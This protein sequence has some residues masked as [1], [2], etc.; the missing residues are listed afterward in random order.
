M[1]KAR[2]LVV[3]DDVNLARLA[4]MVLENSGRYHVM[5]EC[6]STRA[7]GVARHFRP[8]LLLLDVDMPVKS[9]SDVLREIEADDSLHDTPVVFL[10]G[11]LKKEQIGDELHESAGKFFLSKP[12]LP[13]VLLSC[14]AEVLGAKAA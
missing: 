13:E 9:G 8:E 2:V 12:V 7:L 10:T 3:D 1:G 6:D 4:A 11:M 14:V 5:T